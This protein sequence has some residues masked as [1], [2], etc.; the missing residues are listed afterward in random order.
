M[1][2]RITNVDPRGDAAL[3]LLLDAVIDVGPLYIGESDTG[4]RMPE[5]APLGAR[6]VYVV[7]WLSGVAVACGAIRELDHLTAE[8]RRMY[9]HR[10]YR[11]N[12]YARAILTYLELEARRLGYARLLLETGN[13]QQPAMALYEATGFTRVQPYGEHVNDPT[14][15]CYELIL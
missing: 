9:V 3:A 7:A 8:V 11:R 5:N 2:L 4:L 15:V 13:R 1:D 14:S 12:G 10:D 6:D